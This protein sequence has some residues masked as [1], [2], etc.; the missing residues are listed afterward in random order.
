MN[1]VM[2]IAAHPDDETLG[3]GGTIV[4]HTTNKDLVK[5]IFISEGVTSRENINQNEIELRRKY[6]RDACKVLG[7][8]E[9]SFFSFPDNRLDTIPLLDIVQCIE[10]EIQKFM[11]TIIYT[12][13]GTDLN[14]DHKIINKATL[15]ACRPQKDDSIKEIYSFEVLSSTEWS[16]VYEN[17]FKPNHF[18][19]ISKYIE[20][21]IVAMSKYKSEINKSPH[22]RSSEV[23]RALSKYRGSTSGFDYAE[24]YMLERSRVN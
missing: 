1:N 16:S 4:K 21:K 17:S 2:I 20:T 18:V 7:V 19:D 13:S 24:A 12:H 8:S 23:I 5:I 14:I 6:A 3:C 22:P 11:P 15:T 9:L 10:T